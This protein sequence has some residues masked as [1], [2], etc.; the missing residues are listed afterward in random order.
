MI[1]AATQWIG[2]KLSE[3]KEELTLLPSKIE[4]FF[5]N[6]GARIETAFQWIWE[7]LA[8]AFETLGSIIT[9]A[10]EWIWEH[11]ATAFQNVIDTLNTFWQNLKNWMQAMADY[12]LNGLKTLFIPE[13]GYM[14]AKIAQMRGKFGI[15]DSALN[16][17][18][19]LRSFFY[20][21]GSKPPVIY[22][23]L[24]AATGSY[25]FGGETIFVDMR[26]YADYKPTMD[27]VL[28]AILWLW[29]VWR[30]MIALPGIIQGFSGYA[31][32]NNGQTET[33][34]VLASQWYER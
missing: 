26:W 17:F 4:I 20:N 32:Q 18:D 33:G 6:L 14:D 9:T 3:I 2:D 13:K 29:F 28:S 19:E 27:L 8:A 12:L 7:H 22:I 23:D 11:L 34:M 1:E 10:F 30:F 24:S 31:P 16:T 5:D 25:Y 15:V 21:L